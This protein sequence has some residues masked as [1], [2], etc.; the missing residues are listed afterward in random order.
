[1]TG[2]S[3]QASLSHFVYILRAIDSP[4]CVCGGGGNGLDLSFE[5]I[6]MATVWTKGWEGIRMY[7]G[8][9]LGIIATI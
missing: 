6:T 2:L 4:L 7:W 9:L 8:V 1:M 5:N 3:T